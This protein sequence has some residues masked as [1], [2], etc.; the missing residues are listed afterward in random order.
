MIDE[1]AAWQLA[2]RRY[3][4]LSNILFRNVRGQPDKIGDVT[5]VM[6]VA[7]SALLLAMRSDSK[8]LSE[9]STAA[10]V[11]HDSLVKRGAKRMRRAKSTTPLLEV[12][13]EQVESVTPQ[14]LKLS[15]DELKQKIET[16]ART[17]HEIRER[18]RERERRR[19]EVELAR[20]AAEAE[21][22]RR[23][24]EE[25]RLQREEQIRE[26]IE[27][28]QIRREQRELE[29]EV[30]KRRQR[31]NGG[32]V[33]S[34]LKNVDRYAE[35]A[36]MQAVE[37]EQ[38]RQR[39]LAD[40]RERAHAPTLGGLD[41]V[42]QLLEQVKEHGRKREAEMRE[43]RIATER[44]YVPVY[45]GRSYED[46]M[47]EHSKA[48][49]SHD[50]EKHERLY[51]QLK[52][53]EYGKMVG[54]LMAP[55]STDTSTARV[56]PSSPTPAIRESGTDAKRKKLGDEYLRTNGARKYPP[57]MKLE[58]LTTLIDPDKAARE[59]ELEIV[60]EREK[61]GLQY[62]REL[63][64]KVELVRQQKPK[65]VF[66]KSAVVDEIKHLR[67]KTNLLERR[68]L[69]GTGESTGAI[70][71]GT[72]SSVELH[73]LTDSSTLHRNRDRAVGSGVTFDDGVAPGAT[74]RSLQPFEQASFVDVVHAK[75][76]ML[77][78][79]ED[80]KRHAGRDDARW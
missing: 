46:A 33:V 76:E 17:A 61:K 59:A 52:M 73:G 74:S 77:R 38:R 50:D 15:V 8:L 58:P 40:I 27:Q 37:E 9:N 3:P 26:R 12:G 35:R 24:E 48:K 30:S 29:H 51:K 25:R 31:V 69:Y 42:A 10:V 64:E 18:E 5:S 2:Y 16:H 49:H 57:G 45:Q 54:Q 19:L 43:Y 22:S 55:K 23:V 62:L 11:Q 68:L 36:A 67:I 66:N 39:I 32:G 60:K 21:A 79:L 14:R 4:I 1:D 72:S 34:P 80:L 20:V 75:L 13:H 47:L 53:N 70:G 41:R 71:T 78:K 7:C 6:P 63:R 56:H 65:E 28:I 44:N